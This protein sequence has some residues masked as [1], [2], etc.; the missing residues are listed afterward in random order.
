MRILLS[1]L[2]MIAGMCAVQAE[3]S[4]SIERVIPV[5]GKQHIVLQGFHSAK[6]KMVPWEKQEVSIK[7][8]VTV[9]SGDE[10]QELDY[11]KALSISDDSSDGELTVT[12]EKPK[13]TT[14]NGIMGFFRNLFRGG[15]FSREIS[16]EIYVPRGNSFTSDMRYGTVSVSG[17]KGEINFLGTGNAITI[18]ECTAVKRIENPYG[19]IRIKKSGG[20][21]QLVSQSSDQIEIEEF[22]GTADLKADYSDITVRSVSKSVSIHN[23]SGSNSIEDIQ[24]NVTINANYSTISILRV[25]GDADITSRSSAMIRVSD[26]GGVKIDAHYSAMTVSSIRGKSGAAAEIR[27][28]S[29]TVTI[30]D[31]TGPLTIDADYSEITMAGING[32]NGA[33]TSITNQSGSVAIK[34]LSGPLTIDADYSEITLTGIKGDVVL[35]TTSGTVKADSVAGNWRSKT[36]YS[37]INVTALRAQQIVVTNS[38]NPVK[39]FCA[40]APLKA[41]IR[42]TYGDVEMTIPSSYSGE[43]LL[44]AKYGTIETDFPVRTKSLGGGAYA[45]GKVGNGSG[46]IEIE[47]TS[48]NI[49]VSRTD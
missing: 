40:S 23:V 32:K 38:S 44:E 22:D 6:L 20:T 26:A 28:Q 42:N 34:D 12:F 14:V 10:S 39:F 31:L 21:L 47:T 49:N 46:S 25:K 13:E 8:S 37:T 15:H 29:G 18:R 17:M 45:V 24:G 41:E 43:V 33:G 9:S 2:F 3:Q 1:C 7:L 4:R 19:K 48:G 36:E 5:S 16:G 30:D 11:L 27:N 35:N